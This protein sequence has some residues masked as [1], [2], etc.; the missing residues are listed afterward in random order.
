M[1]DAD[2]LQHY[3]HMYLS[4]RLQNVNSPVDLLYASQWIKMARNTWAM[5]QI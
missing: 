2:S 3:F 1:S 4:Q 5:P